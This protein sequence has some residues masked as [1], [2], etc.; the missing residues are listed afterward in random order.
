MGGEL[1]KVIIVVVKIMLGTPPPP[2]PS[3]PVMSTAQGHITSGRSESG[4]KINNSVH[5]VVTKS[6]T[7]Y[8]ERL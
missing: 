1:K 5:R 7:V 4:Y 6:I 8:I 2:P 3:Q